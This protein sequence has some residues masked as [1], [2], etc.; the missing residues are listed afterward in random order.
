MVTFCLI[1]LSKSLVFKKKEDS[2]Y[3]INKTDFSEWEEEIISLS[4][5]KLVVKNKE[6]ME[7]YYK[8]RNDIKL[9]TNG[10]KE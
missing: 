5:D 10:K 6:G 9:E 7:Y 3:I 1:I 8:K 4:N 2:Y